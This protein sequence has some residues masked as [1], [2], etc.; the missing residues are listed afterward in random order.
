MADLLEAKLDGGRF[1]ERRWYV[2]GYGSHYFTTKEDADA[3]IRLSYQV[4]TNARRE[5]LS[6]IEDKLREFG[7]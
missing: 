7:A 3:A 4:A 1:A 6:G 5:I 2:D